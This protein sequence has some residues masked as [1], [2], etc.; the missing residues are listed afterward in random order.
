MRSLSLGASM[1]RARAQPAMPLLA[2]LMWPPRK[3]MRIMSPMAGH[4]NNLYRRSYSAVSNMLVWGNAG[5]GGGHEATRLHCHIRWCS[6]NLAAGGARSSRA[7]RWSGFSMQLLPKPTRRNWRH[8]SRSPLSLLGW[9]ECVG[10]LARQ[11]PTFR[12]NSDISCSAYKP[13]P[14]K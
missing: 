2:F 11:T 1:L 10:V 8:S 3:D 4:L 7:C 13:E 14:P 12:S 6:G 9:H 5:L